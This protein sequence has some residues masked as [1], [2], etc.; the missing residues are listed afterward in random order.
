MDAPRTLTLV[1]PVRDEEQRLPRFLEAIGQAPADL[2]HAGLELFEV[3]IVD[4]GSTDATVRL[5]DAASGPGELVR[6][7][8][9]GDRRG[10]GAAM[11]LGLSEAHGELVLVTDVDLS[12]PLGEAPKLLAAIRDGADLAI[13][14]RSRAGAAVRRSPYRRL[15]SRAFNLLARGLTGLPFADTQCGFK[16]VRADVARLLVAERLVDGYCFDVELLMRA[17]GAG[18]R[19]DEVPVIWLQDDN[20]SL[21]PAQAAWRMAR[22]TAYLAWR[23]R[24][25][26]GARALPKAVSR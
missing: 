7:C 1:V 5:A 10:K 8:A 6:V 21:R 19:V 2:A 9:T 11:A 22:D 13:G 4:D 24:L 25:R 15:T 26:G 20:S 14:S 23:L 3:L 16:L 18:L 17:R 12:S